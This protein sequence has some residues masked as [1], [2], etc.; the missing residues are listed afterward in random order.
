[1]K[2]I[3]FYKYIE[4]SGLEDL[5]K[6]LYELCSALYIKGRILIAK[7]GING[8]VTGDDDKIQ[9]FIKEMKS[10]QE[11]SD[12]DFKPGFTSSHNFKKL[13]VRI[14]NE[15]VTSAL[16]VNLENRGSYIEAR[17]L[18]N[19]LDRN[20]DIILLD[21]RNDYEYRIGRFKSAV[22]PKIKTFREFSKA[23]SRLSHLKNKKIVT[24]CTGGV[25]CEKAS[26]YLKE[27]GFKYVQQLH[28][29]IIKYGLEVGSDH[30]E[31]KC[32]VFDTRGA[33]DIDPKKQ[34]DPVSQ[35]ELCNIPCA[36][37]H[38][39]QVT[40]CDKRYISCENCYELLK[41]CC[42][43]KCRNILNQEEPNR[44]EPKRRSL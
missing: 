2:N 6:S 21:V 1:M 17:E 35:C 24:Y 12:I 34:L 5:G 43:K 31:G 41:G 19:Q 13:V 30:W 29:G 22:N 20:D 28:G 39:C 7:E 26:A 38:N 25:R 8:C 16:N 3:I 42:S 23:V 11:F 14:R 44:E 32:F 40:E 36:D 10:R 27:Q 9:E 33:I 4:L 37:Y 15:I 18:K